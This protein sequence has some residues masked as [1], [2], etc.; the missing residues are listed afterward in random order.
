MRFSGKTALITGGARGRGE[1]F[2]RALAKEGAAIAIADIDDAAAKETAASIEKEHGAALGMRC[3][4]ANESDVEAAVRQTCEHFGGVDILINNAAKH[5]MEYNKPVTQLPLD[6][7]RL[8]LDVNVV[9]I[10]S[11]AAA[12]RE[13]MR[14]R[15]GGVIVSM[16]SIS[17]VASTTP[18]GV[19]KLA[20]RGLTVALAHELAADGI[21]VYAIAPGLVD[22]PVA[23]ADVPEE[24]QKMIVEQ[25][26]LIKRPGRMTDLVGALFFFCSDEA[27]FITGE[28]LIVGGGSPTR[29]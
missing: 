17:G 11:C 21:R 27:S 16:S 13:S 8:M 19:S 25:Q 9:G 2:G 20:V 18:Y 15:G 28:M 24:I 22:S 23:M 12:C 26:Q 14:E 1:T 10:V 29:I 3:D 7:W 5:L 4:V 6:K